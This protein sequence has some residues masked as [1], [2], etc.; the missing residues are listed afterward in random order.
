MEYKCEIC[1]NK[2]MP[3]RLYR[4]KK[5]GGGYVESVSNLCGGCIVRL[6]DEQESF[7][8]KEQKI[9]TIKDTRIG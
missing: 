2:V 6:T 7:I 4:L 8:P 3:L 5:L 1:G 9:H